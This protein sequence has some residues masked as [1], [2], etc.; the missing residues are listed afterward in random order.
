MSGQIS[1]ET[2]TH[3]AL[4]LGT[5]QA[6][7]SLKIDRFARAIPQGQFLRCRTVELLEPGKRVL[8]GWTNG[9]VDPVVLDEVIT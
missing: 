9:G 8:V 4:E 6:D 3:D 7:G 1:R 2:P 5:L